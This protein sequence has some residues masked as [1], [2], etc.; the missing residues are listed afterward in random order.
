MPIKSLPSRRNG[1]ASSYAPPSEANL[2]QDLKDEFERLAAANQ[3]LL[4]KMG[5][6]HEMET[7]PPVELHEE[8]AILRSENSG[9][10]ARVEE[11]EQLISSVGP[12]QDWSERQRE[13]ENL[14]EEKS[15]IIRNLHLKMQE[16]QE[17]HSQSSHDAPFRAASVHNEELDKARRELEEHRQQ[18]EEDEETLMKQMRD[19][20][21]SMSRDRAELARQRAEIQRM[22]TELAREIEMAARDPGLRE[23]LNSLQRRQQDAAKGKLTAP[24]QMSPQAPAHQTPLPGGDDDSKK[25][26]GFF[27][28]MFG[29]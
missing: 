11:Y 29:R 13:Y 7:P 15:E 14:L 3:E 1:A 6:L 10:R 18:L 17:S 4:S 21:M 23:R 20:E 2:D 24:M 12:A 9:L 25:S 27:K 16:L 8:I 22:H 19:M 5:T 28:R 26:S